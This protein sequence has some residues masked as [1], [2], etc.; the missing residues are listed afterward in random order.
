MTAGIS[1][2]PG[3]TGAHR[4]PL[5]L[6]ST[7]IREFF[8]ILLVPTE[9]GGVMKRLI[10]VLFAFFATKGASLFAFPQSSPTADM[11]ANPPTLRLYI[12]DCQLKSQPLQVYVTGELL[13]NHAHRI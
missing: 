4:A 2:I 1:L 7:A 10:I 12:P 3:K 8:S 13:A 6:D 11:T 5:Q 9:S